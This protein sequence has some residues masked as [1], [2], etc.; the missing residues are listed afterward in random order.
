MFAIESAT[1]RATACPSSTLP[2]NDSTI[3]RYGS[4]SAELKG[5]SRRTRPPCVTT[6]SSC[7]SGDS[8]LAHSSAVS[9]P[10]KCNNALTVMSTS[11]PRATA[12]TPSGSPRIHLAALTV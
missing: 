9:P 6:V 8:K 4:G 11:L 7:S 10:G 3:N 1:G 5:L 12:M 2:P